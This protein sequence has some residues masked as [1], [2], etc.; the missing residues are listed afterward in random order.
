MCLAGLTGNRKAMQERSIKIIEQ[1]PVGIITFDIKGEID[2]INQ[3]FKKFGVLYQF[4][5]PEEIGGNVF[6]SK[7]FPYSY[8]LEEI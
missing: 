2:Y 8:I 7:I 3:N 6:Q 5:T 1:V 4:E